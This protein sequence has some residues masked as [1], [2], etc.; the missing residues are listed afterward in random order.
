MTTLLAI[1]DDP[2]RYDYLRCLLAPRGVELVV[3]SC[4]DCIAGALPRAAA[5][6][7]DYDL[8]GE[9]PCDCCGGWPQ[10][11]KGLAYVPAIVAVGLPV[12]VTSASCP[13]NR[14]ALVKALRE[15]G[16]RVEQISAADVLPELSWLGQLWAWG[17]L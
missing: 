13:A 14:T 16:A 15:G 6:L 9:D 11:A 3:A 5:V 1:D 8:D 17:V 2:G 12:L 7:L 4:A 10:H